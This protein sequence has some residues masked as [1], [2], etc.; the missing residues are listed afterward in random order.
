MGEELFTN[1]DATAT[2]ATCV[3]AQS[4][5][6]RKPLKHSRPARYRVA[7]LASHPTQYQ[8]PMLR[9]LT[10]AEALDVTALYL[11][12]LS[13][14]SYHDAGFSREIEWGVPL[15]EGYGSTFVPAVGRTDHLSPLRPFSYGLGRR[16]R[17]GRFDA[18][19]VP[20]YAHQAFVRA[21][22]VAKA[23]GIKVFLRGESHLKSHPRGTAR[24]LAKKAGLTGLFGLLDGFLAIGSL[25]RE[26]YLH[27]G[28]SGER[29]FSMPYSVDNN[30]F[31]ESI[32]AARQGREQL[33][34][35]LGLRSA[36]PVILFASKFQE[37]KRAMDVLQAYARL[38]ADGRTEPD[39]DLVFVGDGEERPHIERSARDL[40]WRSIKVVGFK[41]QTELPR[42]Y[43]LC[44]VFVLPSRFET[45]GLVVNEVMNAGKPVI[46]SDQVGCG[47]DLVTDGGNGY[48][49]PV[50]DVGSLAGRM[51]RLIDDPQLRRRMGRASLARVAGWSFA[52]DLEGLRE[53]L[54]RVVGAR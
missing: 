5:G 8:A 40:G 29:I 31:R 43:D 17:A 18:L 39:A 1:A 52:A 20:G 21:I 23:L 36:R 4:A 32:R 41:N 7:F 24:L 14:R 33:R 38:S 47:P 25:N 53:A 50:G 28:V 19:V 15:L 26:Y 6:L 22:F 11:S 44:D 3:S 54:D 34:R 16:L 2:Q 30:F 45:W 42:F 9:Y 46:V 49:F 12:D 48:V 35:E 27:Y 10:R 37:H 13:T 51:R